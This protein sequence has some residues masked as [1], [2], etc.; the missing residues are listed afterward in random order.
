VS[1]GGLFITLVE[2]GFVNNLGFD[3]HQGNTQLRKDAF[4]FGESQSRVVVSVAADCKQ[5]VES[6]LQ[7]HQQP[8]QLL[9]TVHGKE[10]ILDGENWGAL[11]HWKKTYDERISSLMK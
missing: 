1:E 7:S 3:V 6:F 4:W 9:G 8:F 2:S 10:V 11:S 5:A